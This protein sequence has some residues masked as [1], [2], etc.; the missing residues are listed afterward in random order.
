[1]SRSSEDIPARKEEAAKNAVPGELGDGEVVNGKCGD[2]P[3]HC[4]KDVDEEEEDEED[5]EKVPKV[6]DLGPMVSIKDQLEKD[7]VRSHFRDAIAGIAASF[8]T[9]C[10]SCS[11]S[12][13][14]SRCISSF[15]ARVRRMTRACG[16]GRSSSSAAW[17]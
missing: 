9:A 15:R 10:R 7:K 1:M 8:A 16:G 2:A 4:R 6:I 14:S 11:F 5:E 17:I 12:Y 13:E 3:P